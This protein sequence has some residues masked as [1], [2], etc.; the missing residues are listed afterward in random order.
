MKF[1]TCIA[2]EAHYLKNRDTKRCKVLI[3][4]LMGSK[5]IILLSGTPMLSKPVEIYNLLQILRPDVMCT[6]KDFT[7]RYCKP[8]ETNF[9]MDYNGNSCTKELCYILINSLMIRRLKKDVLKELPD[10]RR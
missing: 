1:N 4:I 8:K 6:F 10:K 3:P 9:G 7:V 2:D 5:R